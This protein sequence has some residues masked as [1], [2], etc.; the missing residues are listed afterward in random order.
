MNKKE[1]A[2][3]SKYMQKQEKINK[4]KQEL[5]QQEPE[6]AEETVDLSE[7]EPSVALAKTT[8]LVFFRQYNTYQAL[9]EV[10]PAEDL[11]AEAIYAKVILYIMRWFRNRLGDDIYEDNPSV[12]FLRDQYPDPER[13]EQ[14]KLDE[15]SN[16]NG[17]DFI[18]FETAFINDKQAWVVCLS[19]PDNGHERN[20]IQGRTFTTEISVYKQAGS[21]VLGIKESCREPEKNTEDAFGYRPG[22]VRDIF[23][24]KDLFVTEQGLDKEYAFS[25]TAY[26]LNGKSG[27]SCRTL[28]DGLIA[29]KGRQMPIL[30]VPGEYYSTH[31]EEVDGKT[32]SL[33]GYCHVVVLENGCRKLFEQIMD[34]SELVDVSE[35]GQFIFYRS[36]CLQDYPSTYFEDNSDDV[37]DRIKTVAQN[38]PLRK[39]CDFREFSFKPSWSEEYSGNNDKKDDEI[40]EIRHKFE[41]EIAQI[42]KKVN[43]LE[44]DNDH[45]QRNISSLE[46]E[47]KG[48]D[49]EI[50]KN[51]AEISRNHQELKKATE[52]RNKAKE[53]MRILKE[54]SLRNEVITRGMVSNVKEQYKPLINL[55]PLEREKKEEILNWINE[56]YSDVLVI[57]PGAEK[58][59][60]DDKRNI[61]LHRL[62]MMIHYIA[63][64]TKYRNNGG[65]AIDPQA[66]REY[67]VEDS[68]Y[69]IEPTGSGQGALELHKDKYTISIEEGG[70]KQD[71]LM[72]LHLKYG[73]GMDDNMIRIYFH[74]SPL[75]K[76][77][78]LGY[79]PGHLPIRNAAH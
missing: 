52:E 65:R 67:D 33:L 47:N 36:N 3:F 7:K 57:H 25:K 72:D 18:E 23:Y 15:V 51:I 27:E 12:A 28:Y 9:L 50:G 76:K 29:S 1:R 74:Y 62:C 68:A 24:D 31:T 46:S 53:E 22:F 20:D 49:K 44:R 59:F 71:V 8:K 41:I 11:K 26:K 60:I 43:D 66:A 40:E 39:F 35:E 61:D 30:F 16:I 58:A 2:Q 73:K 34:N 69:K 45:L 4:K 38:E 64:Y 54:K 6:P 10:Y 19:E 14:F 75:E 55:P 42:K 77:S 70:Q 56:Y 5:L 21:V 48:L 63:G 37:L 78:F 17:F 79:M 32:I 13:Y